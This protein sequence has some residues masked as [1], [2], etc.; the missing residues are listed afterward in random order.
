MLTPRN[1]NLVAFS[2]LTSG[3]C[4]TRLP[5]SS[6]RRRPQE[7]VRRPR[8]LSSRLLAIDETVLATQMDSSNGSPPRIHA[9]FPRLAEK[10]HPATSSPISGSYASSHSPAPQH[11]FSSRPSS[12]K[13]TP[14]LNLFCA[15][16]AWFSLLQAL[17]QSLNSSRFPQISAPSINSSFQGSRRRMPKST[18]AL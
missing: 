15:P 4:R 18:G 9:S 16:V 5:S 3:T 8:H 12:I 6:S 7:A 11:V 10:L 2:R 14:K 1:I 13:K 17:A